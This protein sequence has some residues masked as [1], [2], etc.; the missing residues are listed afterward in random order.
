[1]V[2]EYEEEY[3]EEAPNLSVNERLEGGVPKKVTRVVT[4]KQ[5]GSVKLKKTTTS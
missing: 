4:P 3:E 5:K 1:M 2:E